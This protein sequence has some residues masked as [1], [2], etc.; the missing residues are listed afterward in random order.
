MA[1]KEFGDIR[2][3]GKG[4][5]FEKTQAKYQ[6]FKRDVPKIIAKNSVNWFKEGFRKGGGRGGG[7]TDDSLGGWAPR[8]KRD[9]TRAILVGT[10]DKKGGARG[11]LRD[12]IKKLKATWRQIIV[13][14]TRIPYAERHN[15]GLAGMPKREFIGDSK[16]LNKS[17]RDLLADE[18]KDVFK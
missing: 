3:V 16:G 9:T 10:A 12:S 7:Q 1:T 6:E 18:L 8:L 4:F 11:A 14:T 17:N 5:E 13:G 2:R 15:E